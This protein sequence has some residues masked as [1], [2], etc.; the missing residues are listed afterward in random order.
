MVEA[1]LIAAGRNRRRVRPV[2][3]VHDRRKRNRSTYPDRNDWV[4]PGKIDRLEEPTV[5]EA[6]LVGPA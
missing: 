5:I 6:P 1:P 4:R 2:A 3:D